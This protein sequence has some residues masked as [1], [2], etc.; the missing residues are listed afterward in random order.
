MGVLVGFEE[1]LSDYVDFCSLLISQSARFIDYAVD[2]HEG[3]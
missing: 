1:L 2:V 3:F